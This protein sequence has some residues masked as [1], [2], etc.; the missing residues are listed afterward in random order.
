[1]LFYLLY[2]LATTSINALLDGQTELLYQFNI[3]HQWLTR[4]KNRRIGH[5]PSK[6]N[7]D[8]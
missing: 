4:D 5:R 2:Y 1:M 6:Y 7:I 8:Q 3:A